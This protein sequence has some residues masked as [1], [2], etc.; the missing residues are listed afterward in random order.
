MQS[1]CIVGRRSGLDVRCA[2]TADPTTT[3]TGNTVPQVV[4]ADRFPVYIVHTRH[5]GY[6]DLDVVVGNLPL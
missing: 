3:D 6:C 1:S 5:W 2:G 4:C